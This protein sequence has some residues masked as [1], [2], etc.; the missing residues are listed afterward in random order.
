MDVDI[1]FADNKYEKH[2]KFIRASR[3]NKDQLV[4]H[5]VGVY[6]QDIPIDNTTG[7]SAIPYKDA[8]DIGYLK[9][10][11]LHL[12]LLKYFDNNDQIERLSNIEPDWSLLESEENV[13]KLFQ[14]HR[15]FWLINQI[16]PQ[17]IEELADCLALVR[18]G[19][20]QLIYKY[21]ENKHEIRKIL[22]IK[23]NNFS[24]KRSHAIAYATTIVLQLHLLKSGII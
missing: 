4:K 16:K 15:S 2:F 14:I 5:N 6:F 7:L 21:L 10:D 18:P 13:K 17:N 8:E 12:D 1:D 23:D 20:K 22:Y 11:F 24:F 9:L 19:K 3:I